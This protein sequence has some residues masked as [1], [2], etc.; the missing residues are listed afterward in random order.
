MR[1]YTISERELWLYAR[2]RK[3]LLVDLREPAEYMAGHLPGAVNIPFDRFNGH[4]DLL[5]AGSFEMVVFY[6][7]RGNLSLRMA[8]SFTEQGFR[9]ASLAGG[10]MSY[11]G[12]LVSS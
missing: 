12:R 4:Y 1:G 9:A 3:L 10:M 2:D 7:E 8:R 11:G 5:K 6:C